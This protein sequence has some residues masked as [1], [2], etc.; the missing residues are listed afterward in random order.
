MSSWVWTIPRNSWA[1]EEKS[2]AETTTFGQELEEVSEGRGGG[3]GE[4]RRLEVRNPKPQGGG[5]WRTMEKASG[6]GGVEFI[7][8]SLLSLPLFMA[9]NFRLIIYLV[10]KPITTPLEIP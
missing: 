2:I 7:S 6:M 8:F 5:G 1:W 9:T 4:E 3:K 10:V